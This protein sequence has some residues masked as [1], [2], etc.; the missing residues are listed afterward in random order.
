MKVVIDTNILVSGLLCP[1]G[2]P[3]EIV[4]MVAS[5]TLELC[6]DARIISEY[7]DVLLR[8]KFPFGQFHVDS[9]LDQIK[10]CGHLVG[11]KPL[12]ERLPHPDDE[13]F[14]EVAIVGKARCL[15][16]GNL[17]HYPSKKRQ[18]ILV[19]SPAEFLEVYRNKK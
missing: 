1:F 17:K 13:S 5:G 19:V 10:D 16:T 15:V 18:G 11:A 14:L 4:L 6:Y 3:G 7:R 2:A 9:L 12:L 8:P